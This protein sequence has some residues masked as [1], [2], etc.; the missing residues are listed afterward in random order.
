[1]KKFINIDALSNTPKQYHKAKLQWMSAEYGI[2]IAEVNE[3]YD[4]EAN[5]EAN[6]SEWVKAVLFAA[7]EGQLLSG[8]TLDKLEDVAPGAVGEILHDYPD[9]KVPAGYQTPAA[10]VIEKS[11]GTRCKK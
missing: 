10:K 4:T 2:S 1:M 8:K 11:R 5:Q 3:M 7:K 6:K 9:A